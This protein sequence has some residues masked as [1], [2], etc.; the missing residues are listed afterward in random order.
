MLEIIRAGIR[1]SGKSFR[2]IGATAGVS[3]RT[4]YGLFDEDANPT[5]NTLES[6]ADVLLTIPDKQ[7]RPCD[8]CRH[9]E[10]HERIDCGMGE[11]DAV[12][13]RLGG[14]RSGSGCCLRNA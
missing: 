7:L 1:A 5:I 14:M 4:V 9:M 11:T 10:H 8:G 2:I 12:V 6:I 13:C 3:E